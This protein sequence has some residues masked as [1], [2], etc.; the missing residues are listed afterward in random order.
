M[1]MDQYSARYLDAMLLAAPFAIAPLAWW[2]ADRARARARGAAAFAALF[3]PYLASAAVCGWLGYG[4][5]VRG[6]A[7]DLTQGRA[8]DE[9]ALF[10]ALAARGVKFAMADYWASYRLTF[11]AEESLVVVP[12]NASEDRW[13]PYRD[14]FAAAPVV[15]YLFD[16]DRSREAPESIERHLRENGVVYGAGEWLKIGRF[17]VLVAHRAAG[18]A[19]VGAR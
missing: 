18:S 5:F 7:V 4:R 11:L 19:I 10:A 3:A 16:P 9:R 13:R 6:P 2:V 1:V 14:G 17:T 12:T 8:A 15:A